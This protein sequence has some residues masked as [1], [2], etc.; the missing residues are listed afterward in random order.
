MRGMVKVANAILALKSARSPHWDS[1]KDAAMKAW[2]A[3]Y[4][5]WMETDEVP[6]KTARSAKFVTILCVFCH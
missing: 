1:K 2:M 6:K 5:K 3:K 4:V